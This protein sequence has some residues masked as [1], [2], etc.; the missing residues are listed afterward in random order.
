MMYSPQPIAGTALLIG[1][2]QFLLL[3]QIAEYVYPNYS[4]SQNYISDLGATCRSGSCTVFQPSAFIFNGSII[5]LGIL[6][7]ISAYYLQKA[8]GRKIFSL[9]VLFAGL[10]AIGV[11]LFPETSGI[12]H[13]V[14]SFITFIFI[15]L[16]SLIS[17]RIVTSPLNYVSIILGALTLVDMVLFITGNFLGLGV[18]GMERMIVYPTLVWG[19]AFAGYLINHSETKS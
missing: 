4:T 6:V 5:V 18:G 8:F 1:M 12:I 13:L 16:A 3:L 15:G 19:I 11:G 2:V 10:G 9:F 14:V 17:Y 7:V